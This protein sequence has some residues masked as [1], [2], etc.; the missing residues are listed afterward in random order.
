LPDGKYHF[1]KDIRAEEKIAEFCDKN[2]EISTISDSNRG[3]EKCLFVLR[4]MAR[5]NAK[6]IFFTTPP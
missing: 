3:K 1:F 5:A 6:K 2:L 4:A